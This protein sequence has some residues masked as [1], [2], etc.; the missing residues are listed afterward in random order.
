VRSNTKALMVIC[1]S[2][3]IGMWFERYVIIPISLTRDYVPSSY[4][5]YTPTW[6]DFAMFFGTIGMFV[7]LMF[8]FI[9]FLPMINIFEMKE[10]LH[11]RG[12]ASKKDAEPA[13]ETA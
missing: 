11:E 6:V 13:G 3:S 9:R 12:H 4:G 5:F 7:F 2:I 10:L 8:L 1:T